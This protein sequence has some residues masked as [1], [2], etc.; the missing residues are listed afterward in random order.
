MMKLLFRRGDSAELCARRRWKS[1]EGA[2]SPACAGT[3]VIVYFKLAHAATDFLRGMDRTT[4]AS[5]GARFWLCA[6][7]TSADAE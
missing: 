7:E 5:I 3:K 1:I 6:R 2:K 4:D